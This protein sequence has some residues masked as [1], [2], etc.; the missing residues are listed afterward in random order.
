MSSEDRLKLRTS[1]NGPEESSTSSPT[2]EPDSSEDSFS[3][4]ASD[5]VP[6]TLSFDSGQ[7]RK[8]SVTFDL[9]SCAV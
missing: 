9:N 8:V 3:L 4:P 7:L 6:F 1:D 5:N 2:L